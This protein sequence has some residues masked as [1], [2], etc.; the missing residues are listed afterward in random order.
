MTKYKVTLDEGERKILLE[1]VTRGSGSAPRI[2]HANILL[3]VDRGEGATLLM[4]DEET[5]KVY[6]TTPKTVYN[7]KKRFVEEG[8]DEALG[9]KKREKPP[10]ITIDGEAEARIVALTCQDPPVGYERWSLRLLADTTVELGILPSISHVAIGD[11]LKKT[12]LSHGYIK[13]GASQSNQ[14]ST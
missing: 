10:K 2:K 5:A 11:L 6:H 3:A 4:T 1:S 13:S 12:R 9:R 7:V 8:L 14:V